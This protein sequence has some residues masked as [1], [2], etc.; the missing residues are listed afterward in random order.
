MST[1]AL[2]SNTPR[3]HGGALN[4]LWHAN[5]P[6]TLTVA[7]SLPR[8]DAGQRRSL[9]WVAAGYLGL[10]A[11]TTWQALRGQSVIAPGALTLAAGGALAG[12]VALAAALVVARRR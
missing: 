4:T 8:L 11:L 12:A 6:L 9:V 5:R 2:L 3:A 7:L 10:I 1:R